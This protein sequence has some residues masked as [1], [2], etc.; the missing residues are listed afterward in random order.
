VRGS[1]PREQV[2]RFVDSRIR[3]GTG[4]EASIRNRTR[5]RVCAAIACALQLRLSKSW[6]HD[7]SYV[8]RPP[9]GESRS[10]SNSDR[11]LPRFRYVYEVRAWLTGTRRAARERTNPASFFWPIESCSSRARECTAANAARNGITDT[12]DYLSH[13]SAMHLHTRVRFTRADARSIT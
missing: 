6:I 2:L 12:L 11:G 8:A 5:T 4:A 10:S 1:K 9:R 3:A 13:G 7:R